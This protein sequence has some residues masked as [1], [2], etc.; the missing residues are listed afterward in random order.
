LKPENYAFMKNKKTERKM[1]KKA[2]VLTSGG[3]D[4]TTV[5]AVAKERGFDLYCLSFYYGQRH[6]MELESAKKVAAFWSKRA[7]NH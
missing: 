4:S 3:L 5:A 2:I 1:A 6:K 7:Y